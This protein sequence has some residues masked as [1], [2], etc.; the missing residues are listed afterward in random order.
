MWLFR[1]STQDEESPDATPLGLTE[2]QLSQ[3]LDFAELFAVFGELQG[4]HPAD[5]SL[6]KKL[7]PEE[8]LKL[9]ALLP[10]LEEFLA[11]LRCHA[12]IGIRYT[13]DCVFLERTG[14][15]VELHAFTHPLRAPLEDR[16][17]T[18]VLT[19]RG[20]SASTDYL[21]DRGR[22][23]VLHYPRPRNAQQIAEICAEV[24]ASAYSITG[25]DE[26][27]FTLRADW[28]RPNGDEA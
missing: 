6:E 4:F 25:G 28:S 10:R 13:D 1:P 26:L 18:A 22:T 27:V 17:F 21:A 16:N 11:D 7:R 23:R 20:I 15:A 24:F 12:Q 5:Q 14:E 3:V 9:H 2:Y 8:V 19:R